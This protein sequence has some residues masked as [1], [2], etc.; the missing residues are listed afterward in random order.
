VHEPSVIAAGTLAAIEVGARGAVGIFFIASGSL[1][2]LRPR[3]ASTAVEVLGLGRRAATAAVVVLALLEVLLG[4][5][6]VVSRARV[7]LVSAV[8]LLALFS[9]FLLFLRRAAPS[10]RCG[11][12]GDL[13]SGNHALGLVRNALLVGL[14]ALGFAASGDLD[15]PSLAIAGQ[16][17]LLVA[18]V[19]EGG[20]VLF[21]VVRLERSYGR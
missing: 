14:L 10:V 19:T 17:A 13:G 15:L 5:V 1:K 20:A 4:T 3:S 16:L 2:L 8:V 11:C 21:D 18:V 9:A 12:L 6:L 7:V